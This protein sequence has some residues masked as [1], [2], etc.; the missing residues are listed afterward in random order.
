MLMMSQFTSA[1]WVGAIREGLP[2][3]MC[4][5]VLMVGENKIVEFYA[6]FCCFLV[7]S[8]ASS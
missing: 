1:N 8:V 3:F 4:L 7:A 2:V 5:F 6:L